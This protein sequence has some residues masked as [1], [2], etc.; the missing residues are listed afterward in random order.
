MNTLED[1][2]F[3]YTDLSEGEQRALE[4]RVADRPEYRALLDEVKHLEAALRR[5]R[6]PDAAAE[7][8]NALPPDLLALYALDAAGSVRTSTRDALQPFFA[9]VEARLAHD[10][11]LQQRVQPMIDRARSLD[12]TFDVQRH[13]HELTGIDLESMPVYATDDTDDTEP[14]AP[15][16]TA[17]SPNGRDAREALGP[18]GTSPNASAARTQRGSVS[19]ARGDTA[20]KSTGSAVTSRVWHGVRSAAIA[21]A[22]VIVAYAALLGVSLATQSPAEQMAVLDP[23][24]MQIEGYQMRTRSATAAPR[25]NDER[26]LRALQ[27]LD[28]AHS[29]PLGLFPTFDADEVQEAQDLLQSVVENEEAGSFLQLEASFFLAKTH[30][31]Q[32]DI[33]PARSALKRVVMGEGRR[34]NEAAQM[35]ESLQRHYPM[36][37]PTLRDGVQL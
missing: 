27:V 10:E 22:V 24:E 33:E 9:S 12:E 2:I 34:L 35:L 8:A 7:A 1:T 3:R 36:E 21:A 15:E 28:A 31:A 5:L 26:F 14:P 20:A 4:D 29:A 19:R 17:Q 32:S 11:A 30:L 16:G 37:E 6:L 23:D 13:L 18:S 25:T